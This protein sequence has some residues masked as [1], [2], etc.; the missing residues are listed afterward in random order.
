MTVRD[1]PYRV[2]GG[3]NDVHLDVCPKMKKVVFPPLHFFLIIKH[4]VFAFGAAL[5]CLPS[6]ISPKHPML[7]NSL[8]A[9]QFA[10]HCILSLLIQK[11]PSFSKS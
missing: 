4:V 7:V 6:S 5:Y 10:S 8:F 11:N 3:T 2:K 9:S 1:R